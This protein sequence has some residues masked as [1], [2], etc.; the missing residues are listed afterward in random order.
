[1]QILEDGP[2]EFLV[3]CKC[4][5]LQVLLDIV[6]DRI[7]VCI[8]VHVGVSFLMSTPGKSASFCHVDDFTPIDLQGF[9]APSNICGNF[10]I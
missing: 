2:T 7:L 5:N 10:L 6:P 8:H 3:P 1:M 9:A 4:I